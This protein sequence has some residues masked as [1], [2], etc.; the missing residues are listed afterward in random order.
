[1]KEKITEQEVLEELGQ[2]I[3]DDTDMDD[4]LPD[5]DYEDNPL[6]ADD[7][8]RPDWDD[9]DWEEPEG[10]EEYIKE[11][12]IYEQIDGLEKGYDY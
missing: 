2:L 6:D 1:M 12:G 11:T 10:L 5:P 8:G 3:V 9:E 4:N 7:A